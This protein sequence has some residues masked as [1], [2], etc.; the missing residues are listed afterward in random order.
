MTCPSNEVP[1]PFS[2]FG[3]NTSNITG[4]SPCLPHLNRFERLVLKTVKIG[5]RWNILREIPFLRPCSSS[6]SA[7]LSKHHKEIVS[8]P[9]WLWHVNTFQNQIDTFC[10]AS[11]EVKLQIS[12]NIWQNLWPLKMSKSFQK[13]YIADESIC[14]SNRTFPTECAKFLC[15]M[16]L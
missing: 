13:S 11:S 6:S 7:C 2:K 10:E 4:I 15:T 8:L 1:S 5:G 12:V 3:I 14:L 16:V 9:V